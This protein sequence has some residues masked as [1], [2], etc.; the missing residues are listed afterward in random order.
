MTLRQTLQA[1]PAK[2]KELIEKLRATSNQAVKTRESLF[3]ELKE[4]LTL[5]LDQEDQHLLPLLRKHAETKALASDAAKASK[6]LRAR[7]TALDGAAKDSDEFAAAV[8]ELQSLLQ[9]HLRDERKQLLPAVSKTLDDEEAA[10][11]AAAIEA[12]F[13]E[14]EKA[15]R[16]EKRKAADAA[17]KEAQLAEEALAAERAAARAQKAAEREAREQIEKVKE[18]AQAPIVRAVEQTREAATQAQGALAAYSGTFQKAA[19]DLRAVSASR[20][21]A[22]QGASQ[23]MSAWFDW[24]NKASQAQAETSRRILGCRNLADFA[25]L[26]SEMVANSTRTLIEGNAAFLEIAQQTST[27]ALRALETERA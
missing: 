8:G 14:A 27:K 15:K 11:A 1:A 24:M 4:Q 3:A 23:F 19:A 18:A 2:T 17:R 12:G 5:Y 9:Q 26:Q 6:E 10:N 13:A 20:T 21:A 22:A 7:L 25:E 16:E